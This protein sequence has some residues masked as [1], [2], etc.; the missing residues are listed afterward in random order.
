MGVG[1][2]IGGRRRGREKGKGKRKKKRKR[3][4]GGGRRKR[5]E[6]KEKGDWNFPRMYGRIWD[7]MVWLRERNG[8][9]WQL[10]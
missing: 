8:W 4:R 6:V 10:L 9:I 3:G 1:I 7:G 2:Y 5:E